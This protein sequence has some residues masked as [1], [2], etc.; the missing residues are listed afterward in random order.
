MSRKRS[1]FDKTMRAIE[2]AG[3]G[4]WQLVLYDAH[5]IMEA[6]LRG[7][8][9][10]VKMIN[11]TIDQLHA[12]ETPICL[13]CLKPMPDGPW[14]YAVLKPHDVPLS[15]NP[16][17]LKMTICR[18]CARLPDVRERALDA[19]RTE[20]AGVRVIQVNENEGHA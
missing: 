4:V 16:P 8:D 13:T 14:K 6:A 10:A 18:S 7:S 17:H 20:I 12:R 1:E 2:K 15:A 11:A 5:D 19:F 3:N 9:H